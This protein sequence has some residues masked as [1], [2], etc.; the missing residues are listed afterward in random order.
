MKKTHIL[1]LPF[2]LHTSM[3]DN[4]SPSGTGIIGTHTLIDGTPGT[5]YVRTDQPDGTT[6]RMTDGTYGTDGSFDAVID[7]WNGDPAATG[8]FAYYGVTGLAIPAEQK[9]TNLTVNLITANDGGWFGPNGTGPGS[10]GVLNQT[11]LTVPT[12]Q[13][14]ADGGRTWTNID[15]TTNTYLST[16][17][18]HFVG[19]P[20]NAGGPTYATVTFDLDTPQDSIDGIR[21]I[22]PEG[23][24]PAGADAGG[25]IGLT[26]FEVNTTFNPTADLDG[27]GMPDSWEALHGVDDPNE[28]SDTDGLTN[29]EEYQN[30]TFPKTADS[31]TD[32]LNDGDEVNT[33]LT[34]PNVSDSD[35]DR[36]GDGDEVTTHLTD[37]KAKDSDL[38]GLEDGEEINT[39]MTDPNLIDSDADG[40]GDAIEIAEGS[41]PN[42]LTSIPA[43]NAALSATG[44]AGNHNEL[45]DLTTLGLPYAHHGNGVTTGGTTSRLTDGVTEAITL[46]TIVD[47]W[48]GGAPDTHSY[49]GVIWDI[50][51]PPA[52]TVNSISLTIATFV[53]GG[54]FGFNDSSPFANSPLEL[55]TH[56]SADSLP[57]VQVTNDGGSTWS[58]VPSSTD[59][60]SVMT[61][62]FI[63]NPPTT[64]TVTWN[65]N[66]P[67]ASIDGIRVIGTHGGSAGDAYNGFLGVTEVAVT[68]GGIVSI[69]ITDISYSPPSAGNES[70]SVSMT[71]NS[72][73]GKSYSIYRSSDLTPSTWVTVDSAVPSGGKITSLTFQNPVP[74]S[75][76]QFF[77]ISQN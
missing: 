45:D 60:L 53:D 8:T 44:I 20:G 47:T 62:H 1:F 57:E 54:W 46:E 10:G 65:L 17:D 41:D 18:G 48:H 13:V 33:H 32:G 59:Y 31:D 27:D 71:W 37:P 40:Y 64:N 21:L 72:S 74:G 19:H 66:S 52:E 50:N 30:S 22:G 70:G 26:E 42:D 14:T 9:I 43:A 58:T 7:T 51:P 34:N 77:R 12:I 23:G 38:D 16:L 28:D 29:L 75:E 2:L 39:Y 25:F 4:I 11:Y 49:A 61:G 24:G 67:Q 5:P 73:A 69:E 76:T 6:L 35:G 68:T 55:D 56:I 15:S 36:L 3:A 63:G